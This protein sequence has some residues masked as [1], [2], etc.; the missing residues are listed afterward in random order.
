MNFKNIFE[1][2]EGG[3]IPISI[4]IF[5]ST[6]NVNNYELQREVKSCNIA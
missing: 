5:T 1:N 3:V 4:S 2:V 6:K